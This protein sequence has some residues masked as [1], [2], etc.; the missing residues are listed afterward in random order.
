MKGWRRPISFALLAAACAASPGVALAQQETPARPTDPRGIGTAQQ[1]PVTATG[2][3][4]AFTHAAT[5]AADGFVL[6]DG[7]A[8]HFPAYLGAKVLALVAQ[9]ARV[10]VTGLLVEG[11]D[12]DAARLIE[13]RTITD[14]RS[15]RTLTVTGT[16]ATQPGSTLSGDE[17]QGGAAGAGGGAA[18]GGA[19]GAAGTAR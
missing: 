19:G 9:N 4:R 17:A 8:V 2:T 6:S 11:T 16:G 1:E 10:R 14:L 13:A 12:P 18:G 7:T 3:V 15:N 5:G